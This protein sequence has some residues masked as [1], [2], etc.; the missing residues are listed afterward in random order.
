MGHL[1]CS[2]C[3]VGKE[4]LHIY[5]E[6]C[7]HIDKVKFIVGAAGRS[8]MECSVFQEFKEKEDNDNAERCR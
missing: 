4:N 8:E 6:Y 2:I 3:A 1:L 7:P 5:P